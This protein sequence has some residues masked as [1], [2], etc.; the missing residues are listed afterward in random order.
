MQAVTPVSSAFNKHFLFLLVIAISRPV[1]A[2]EP[3][4]ETELPDV[5]VTAT[6]NNA[7]VPRLPL[8]AERITNSSLHSAHASQLSQLST[9]L[10]NFSIQ[11]YGVYKNAYIRGAGGGGR[12]AGFDARTAV[13]VDGVNVG[14]TI[15]LESLLFDI[16]QVEVAKGPQGYTHGNQSDTGEIRISTQQVTALP[17]A[18]IKFGVGNLD[19]RETT[20]VMNMPLAEHI[21]SRIALRKEERDGYVTNNI[22][23]QRLKA[24]D[25]TA[26]RA[27]LQVQT[28]EQ[29]RLK[30]YADYADLSDQNFLAQATT[31]MFGQPVQTG[32]TFSH[33]FLNTRPM[34]HTLAQGLSIQS[35]RQLA[36]NAQLE[37]IVAA[38]DHRHSRQT[39]NDYSGNDVLATY[40]KDRHQFTSQEFRYSSD[41][42]QA[43]RYVSG[44]YF[45]QQAQTNDRR[46]VFGNDMTTLIKRPTSSVFTPF[47][48]TFG[49]AAGAEV[50]L[51]AKV[52]TQTQALYANASYGLDTVTLHV[53]GRYQWEQKQLD[54]SLDGAQ[55]GAFRIGSLDQQKQAMANHFFS[56][57]LAVSMQPDQS[58]TLLAKVAKTYKNGGWNVDF[59]NLAQ[60]QDGYAFAPE[61]VNSLELDWHYQHTAF[62]LN[63]ALFVNHY[64][65]YQVF[66]LARLGGGAQVLQLRNA[67]SVRTQGVELSALIPMGQAWLINSKL[68]YLDASYLRFPGG[69][70]NGTDASGQA[71]PDAPRWSVANTLSYGVHSHTLAGKLE[72]SIQHYYQSATY[73]GM[74]SE[75]ENSQLPKR[76]LLNSCLNYTTDN[77]HW[78]W[79]LWVRN[80]TN[81]QVAVAKGKDFLGNQ[82]AIYNEP[83]LVG[84]SGEY[85]F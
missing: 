37:V 10:P 74:S 4:D 38:R 1:V 78:L 40:Y 76:H 56:P 46:A 65:N 27:Q 41:Q 17:E 60:V 15:S 20:L 31:G 84:V 68:A 39:D 72:A 70:T 7:P 21:N 50:P 6:K 16:E 35:E 19:Y 73:S 61:S 64:D 69:S 51:Q 13:Y 79:S 80:L 75:P 54:F 85:R 49:V 62:D 59:L 8:V 55:S 23:Q 12:N 14:P 36:N 57:M 71:L 33:V 67:A 52:N 66:Q 26:A 3:A 2:D 9:L 47:G 22:D 44:L 5:E 29:H 43:L 18:H 81:Q 48:A 83:R 82:I 34:A 53:G 45:S 11:Q 77:R 25:N 58:N 63:T 30:L 32:N 42:Q 24:Q 28:S